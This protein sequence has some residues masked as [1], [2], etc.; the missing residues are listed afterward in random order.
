MQKQKE[1]NG[2]GWKSKAP[3][4]DEGLLVS[5]LKEVAS[6]YMQ[7][8]S[9]HVDETANE[10]LWHSSRIQY[11]REHKSWIGLEVYYH[12]DAV[13]L[14]V[15]AHEVGH[16]E[17]MTEEDKASYK[18]NE[19]ITY[20]IEAKASQWAIAFCQRHGVKGKRL[21]EVASILQGPLDR[22]RARGCKRIELLPQEE[23]C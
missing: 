10:E 19:I 14:P 16:L 17:T 7:A 6:R 18:E 21:Q 22:Y 8:S 2:K 4:V 23:G 1:W 11:S 12:N 3:A 13:R 20:A 15:L 9:V 5:R